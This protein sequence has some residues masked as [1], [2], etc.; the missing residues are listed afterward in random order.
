M[1]PDPAIAAAERTEAARH[2][3]AQAQPE[4]VDLV[5]LSALE[6]CVLDGPRHPA[7]RGARGPCLDAAGEPATPQDHRRGHRRPGRA[8]PPD[9]GD[10]R[11][12]S[13]VKRAPTI[14][15][16]PELGLML[17]ARCR[18]AFIVIAEGDGK[19]CARSASSPSAIRLDPVRG[20]VAEVPSGICPPDR[21]RRL[22]GRPEA[23]AAGL[24]LPLR[25]CLTGE[26]GGDPRQMD[27]HPAQRSQAKPVPA[28]YLVS[29]YRPDRREPVGYHLSVRGDGTRATWTGPAS[30]TA[31]RLQPN[32]TSPDSAES[33]STCSP[34]QSR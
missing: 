22:P 4:I 21:G 19:A 14:R 12:L 10:R 28:R 27:D 34:R 30:A 24:D 20:I 25:P 18:P 2:L 15:L 29:A 32:T 13:P 26:R 33:C 1:M 16:K 9:R 23:R 8:R 6:L 7:V 5:T 11:E 17:A 31:S 3:I